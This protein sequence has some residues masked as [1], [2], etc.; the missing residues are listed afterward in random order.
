MILASASCGGILLRDI[1]TKTNI[2]TFNDY[3]ASFL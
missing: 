3:H 2:V 1:E